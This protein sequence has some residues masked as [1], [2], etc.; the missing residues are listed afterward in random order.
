MITGQRVKESSWL[1]E[2]ALWM[3]WIYVG[4]AQ[5]MEHC[6]LLAFDSDQL[7]HALKKHRLTR[8]VSS[9][10][11]KALNQCVRS[12]QD[13]W[14]NDIYI[15]C[16]DFASLVLSM[17]ASIRRTISAHALG[18]VASNRDAILDRRPRDY[19]A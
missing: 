15:P 12:A 2:A 13:D 18:N 10:Y 17:D 19:F 5:A 6:R 1:C 11:A 14:P 16:S 7:V 4:R 8:E 9:A 3:Q